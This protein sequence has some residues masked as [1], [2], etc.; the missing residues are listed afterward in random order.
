LPH[1]TLHHLTAIVCI[2]P[3]F[4]YTLYMFPQY[5]QVLLH[6]YPNWRAEL[7]GVGSSS[8]STDLATAAATAATVAAAGD[9]TTT[10]AGTDTASTSNTANATTAPS[11]TN[12]SAI[13]TNVANSSSS[14]GSSSQVHVHVT[15][16]H[17]SSGSSATATDT[18]IIAGTRKGATTDD[19]VAQRGHQQQL[20]CVRRRGARRSVRMALHFALMGCLAFTGKPAM[21]KYCTVCNFFIK[22]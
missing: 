17:D 19:D 6:R 1:R 22:L 15:I 14:N 5:F 21:L 20:Q 10:T 12:S 13:D 2:I 4:A 11:A 16:N 18:T 9:A 7:A 8:S 3:A